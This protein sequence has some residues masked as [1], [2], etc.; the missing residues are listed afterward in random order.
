MNEAFHRPNQIKIGSIATK[1]SADSGSGL[2]KIHLQAKWRVMKNPDF[3]KRGFFFI[4]FPTYQN[5][6]SLLELLDLESARLE[7]GWSSSQVVKVLGKHE[8]NRTFVCSWQR[9]LHYNIQQKPSLLH[10]KKQ[11]IGLLGPVGS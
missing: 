8:A 4:F 11:A 10:T 3:S 5:R 1:K 2:K 9:C 7:K 6:N